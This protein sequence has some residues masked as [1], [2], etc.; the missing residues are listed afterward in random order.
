MFYQYNHLGS[1]DYLKIERKQNLTFPLHLHQCFELIILLSGQM[2]V[3]VGER[4]ILLQEGDGTLVFPNQIHSLRSTESEHILCIFSSTL[5]AA[6]AQK[7]ANKLPVA[8][9]FR[10]DEYLVTALK[11]LSADASTMEKKGLL[12]FMC[13]QFH[14]SARYEDRQTGKESLLFRIFSFVE[15]YYDKDCTLY[16]LARQLG[17]DHC[18]L[19]RVFKET[20]GVSFN[21]YVNQYRL[22]RAC[23]LM[24]NTDDTIIHCAYESG[25][26]SIRN[27][28]R[29]FKASFGMTPAQYRR[30]GGIDISEE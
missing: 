1:P 3:Q 9:K 6:Y 17:Y 25:Y 26:S 15:E 21:S 5:V 22:S 18:Y 14:K 24:E 8:G 13:A 16:H 7:V 11:N 27:F 23:Y 19:S 20:V 2:E 30:N 10:P 12:Y 29:N 4:E 28:N